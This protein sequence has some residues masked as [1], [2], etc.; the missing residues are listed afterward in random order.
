MPGMFRLISKTHFGA[1]AAN[2]CAFPAVF[3]IMLFTFFGT[4]IAD[5]SAKLQEYIH[6]FRITRKHRSGKLADVRAFAIQLDAP[7]HDCNIF[8]IQAGIVA[9][10]A[11]NSAGIQFVQKLIVFHINLNI[12]VNI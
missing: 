1:F 5:F 8:F 10:I 3:I 4:G 11:Y 2:P 6:I 9:H 12:Y 7:G